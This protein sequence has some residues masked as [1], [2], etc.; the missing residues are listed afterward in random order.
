M[1]G[2]VV[3]VFGISGVG[4]TTLCRNFVAR[5]P[6]Y[7]H[8]QASELLRE[9]KGVDPE[10]LRQ[11][12]PSE[13]ETNQKSLAFAL[14]KKI[15]NDKICRILLDAHSLIDNGS[16]LVPISPDII[17]S[18][19]PKSLIVIEEDPQLIYERRLRDQRARPI[20]SISE[21]HQ[22]QAASTSQA[23]LYSHALNLPIFILRS[24]SL[25]DFAKALREA[26][27]F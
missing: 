19:R 3:P 22:Q 15:E 1:T 2:I 24:A 27:K 4:K 20:R 6:A 16:T 8:L 21:L 10:S 9:L 23:L 5:N 17:A 7:M 14:Q 12:S 26:S 25:D 13:I 11:S 18:F